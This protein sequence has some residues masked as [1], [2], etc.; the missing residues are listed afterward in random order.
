VHYFV[1]LFVFLHMHVQKYEQ[2]YKIVHGKVGDI[3]AW[4]LQK[5]V[6]L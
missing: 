4:T 3:W 1:L 5:N 6:L 2:E